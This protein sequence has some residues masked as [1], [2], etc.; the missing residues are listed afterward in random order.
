MMFSRDPKGSVEK[1]SDFFFHNENMT[2]YSP[3]FHVYE[4]QL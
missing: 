1:C 3:F 2:F 4:F